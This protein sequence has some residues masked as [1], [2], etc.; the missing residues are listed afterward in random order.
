MAD[1][2]REIAKL[3]ETQKKEIEN[4]LYKILEHARGEL[5]ELGVD[6]PDYDPELAKIGQEEEA[7]EIEEEKPVAKEKNHRKKE[8]Q[9]TLK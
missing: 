7:E 6:N 1:A 2:L 8:K 9:T 3:T 5:E 4:N